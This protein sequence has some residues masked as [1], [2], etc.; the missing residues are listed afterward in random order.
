MIKGIRDFYYN[1]QDM[2][3][4]VRFYSETFGMKKIYG[5]GHWVSLE[6]SGIHFGLHLAS[7]LP[8]SGW[9]STALHRNQK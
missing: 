7:N 9:I 6:I 4:A 8:S 2:N 1:V 3:R 5:N